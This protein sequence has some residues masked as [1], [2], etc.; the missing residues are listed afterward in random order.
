M[1][2]E[3][4]KHATKDEIDKLCKRV[5]AFHISDRMARLQRHARAEAI[6]ADP[7]SAFAL[8][9]L[10]ELTFAKDIKWGLPEA[11]SSKNAGKRR[12]RVRA[13]KK[14]G[15]SHDLRLWIGRGL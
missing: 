11:S 5:S 14:M 8:V 2:T 3:T 12:R 9:L 13:A 1:P 15:Q 6:F 7:A 4:S 10:D